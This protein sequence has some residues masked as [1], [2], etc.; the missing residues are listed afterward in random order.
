MVESWN[1]LDFVRMKEKWAIGLKG[2]DQQSW[3]K[4]IESLRE[5][6]IFL[7]VDLGNDWKRDKSSQMTTALN[8]P[9]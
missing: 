4:E 7:Q 9:E 1:D 2:T 6:T 5:H 8:P 3:R